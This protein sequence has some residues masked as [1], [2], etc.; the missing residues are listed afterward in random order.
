[1]SLPILPILPSL[2]TRPGAPSRYSSIRHRRGW[3]ASAFLGE[4]VGVFQLVGGEVGVHE[5][6][7]EEEGERERL[8]VQPGRVEE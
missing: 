4:T 1:M 8:V 6:E 5:E 3:L 2:Q 7:E